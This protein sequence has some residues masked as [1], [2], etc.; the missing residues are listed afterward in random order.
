MIRGWA[1]F[2]VFGLWT[3]L[4]ICAGSGQSQEPEKPAPA[5]EKSG[6]LP[7]QKE[8]SAAEKQQ[9]DWLEYYYLDPSPERLVEEVKNWSKD[10]TLVNERA[11]PALIGFLS[12]IIKNNE[13]QITAWYDDLAGLSP[14]EKTILHTSMLY[15]HSAEAD[16]LMVKTFGPKYRDQRQSTPGILELPLDKQHTIDMLW[17]YF[18][19]TGSPEALRKIILCFRFL[20]APADLKGV[21]IP[22]GYMPLYKELPRI[23][24]IS[25]AANCE[26]HG[27]VLRVCEEIYANDDS[28]VESEKAELYDLLSE[29]L[30]EK[31][32]V[33]NPDDKKA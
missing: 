29:F 1:R 5:V 3:A 28:L 33:R 24:Y 31:Y 14:E 23:A 9:E 4:F 2:G 15:S 7:V 12:Q 17:G 25:L 11:R 30:P 6:N 16:Q 10:G 32:P 19:A 8:K 13:D 22:Q 26:R 27:K 21:D 18:Y 20:D